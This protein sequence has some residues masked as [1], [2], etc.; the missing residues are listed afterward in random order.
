M[1][2]RIRLH[3]DRV[4]VP[5]HLAGDASAIEAAI[6]SEITRQIGGV[7]ALPTQSRRVDAV[8]GGRLGGDGSLGT[9]IGATVA[10]AVL[11]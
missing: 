5:R 3:I 10:G 7:A 4:V 11:K 9:R 1:T 2:H 6:R 8:D